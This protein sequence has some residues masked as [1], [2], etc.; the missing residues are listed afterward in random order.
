MQL[1]ILNF[2]I[3]KKNCVYFGIIFFITAFIISCSSKDD[4]IL[5][6]DDS[7][8]GILSFSM[9]TANVYNAPNRSM[10]WKSSM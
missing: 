1:L 8:K 5:S 7:G 2:K 6:D 3:M 9:L 4:S 10:N